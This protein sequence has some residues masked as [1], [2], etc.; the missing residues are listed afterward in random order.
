MQTLKKFHISFRLRLS[1]YQKIFKNLIWKNERKIQFDE[2]KHT[3]TVDITLLSKLHN[4]ISGTG[5]KCQAIW[6]EINYTSSFFGVKTVSKSEWN[7]IK[8]STEECW[9]FVKTKR[10][11]IEGKHF[12]FNKRM[13][14]D[15]QGC[16]IEDFPEERFNWLETNRLH[17]IKCSFHKASIIAKDEVSKL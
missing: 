5:F 16:S 4:Q 10:C 7:S 8:L 13:S 9:S 11:V 6:I 12:Q 17:G 1:A 3:S 2:L 15:H 14:C